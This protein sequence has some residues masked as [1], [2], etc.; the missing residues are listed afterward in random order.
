MFMI[1]FKDLEEEKIRKLGNG[2]NGFKLIGKAQ[3]L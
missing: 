2:S 1:T 3:F